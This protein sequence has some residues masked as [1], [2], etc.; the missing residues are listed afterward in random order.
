MSKAARESMLLSNYEVYS[1][2]GDLHELY[3]SGVV[4]PDIE[5]TGKLWVDLYM[6]AIYHCDGLMLC[7]TEDNP[8]LVLAV[9]CTVA[10]SDVMRIWITNK[11][12]DDKEAKDLSWRTDF[13]LQV[14]CAKYNVSMEN[15]LL[16]EEN[17]VAVC[18]GKYHKNGYVTMIYIVGEDM[19][20]Q[21]YEL[22]SN[23]HNW[24][25]SS[26]MFQAWFAFPGKRNGG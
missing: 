12:D 22:C 10:G 8:R 24:P 3:N 14:D 20:K 21:V 1:I 13:V 11:I 16:D 2:P 18:C 26:P 5:F 4:E 7:Q 17:K 19:Y 9:S 25:L 6:Y 15:F 23:L